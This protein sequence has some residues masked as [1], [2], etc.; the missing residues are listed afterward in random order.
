MHNDIAF[1]LRN[2]GYETTRR[3]NRYEA[4]GSA[5]DDTV[6]ALAL[7]LHCSN[8]YG[9]GFYTCYC[10]GEESK[11]HCKSYGIW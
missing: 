8:E 11:R 9:S 4:L 6:I 10:L 1:E 7:A 3:G 5:H 2:F